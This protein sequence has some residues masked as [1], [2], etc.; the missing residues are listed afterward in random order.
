MGK[1]LQC[2]IQSVRGRLRIRLP[3]KLFDGAQRDLYLGL[4]DTPE[5]RQVAQAIKQLID[6]DAAIGAFDR[7]LEKYQNF[8]E[9]AL[10]NFNAPPPPKVQTTATE[11]KLR[12]SS[13][14]APTIESKPDTKLRQEPVEQL[15]L[16]ELWRN[17]TAYKM[18]RLAKNT[19]A[20]YRSLERHLEHLGNVPIDKHH[21][22]CDYFVG[23]S[24]LGIPQI[25]KHLTLLKSCYE[26]ALE[27]ELINCKPF[28]LPKLKAPNNRQA[29]P[30]SA[31]ERRLI[32]ESFISDEQYSYYAPFVSFCF[33]TGCRLS[34]AIGLQWGQIENDCSS[35][36]FDRAYVRGELRPTKTNEVRTFPCNQSL[37]GLLLSVRPDGVKPDVLVFPALG[38]G[39]INDGN[40]ARRAWRGGIVRS[41]ADEG[42]I[43]F[44]ERPYSMRSTFISLALE[45]GV[46]IASVAQLVGNSVEV[47][48]SNYAGVTGRLEVPDF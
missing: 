38:G 15:T 44:Y 3:R 30:F 23:H 33:F 40:F 43:R 36:R 39:Y 6:S 8:K 35:I 22:I 14:E 21:A 31:D 26:W 41:L 2:A 18:P 19:R 13:V 45:N 7:E 16:L 17:Y 37:R 24:E 11:G 12:Q 25:K 48:S 1:Q 46:P 10:K 29:R 9:I 47:I 42:R 28:S 32:I 4:N 34:E 27:R 20:N 5:N